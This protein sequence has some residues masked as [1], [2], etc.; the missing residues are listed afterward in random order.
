MNSIDHFCKLKFHWIAFLYDMLT[1]FFNSY[2]GNG[3]N[4]ITPEKITFT[5][6]KQDNANIRTDQLV[7]SK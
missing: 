2:F 6:A 4:I 5:P 7:S 3:N 1:R